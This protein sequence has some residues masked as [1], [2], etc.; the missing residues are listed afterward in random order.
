MAVDQ[1]S[2]Y[3]LPTVER[4]DANEDEE[5]QAPD[6]RL[7]IMVTAPWLFTKRDMEI[8]TDLSKVGSFCIAL[9]C[10]LTLSFCGTLGLAT[11]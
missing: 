2:V 5:F 1:G 8:F 3:S 4:D 7:V 9:K 11:L 10:L 6:G